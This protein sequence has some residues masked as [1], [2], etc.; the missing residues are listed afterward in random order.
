MV[1]QYLGTGAY[2]NRE[3][4]NRLMGEGNAISGAYLYIDEAQ[5]AEIYQHLKES[6]LGHPRLQF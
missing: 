4:L 6:Y 3:A 5:A 2:M 1:R